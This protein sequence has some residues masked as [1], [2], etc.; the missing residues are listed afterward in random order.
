MSRVTEPVEALVAGSRTAALL[1]S[2]FCVGYGV[3]T[4][5]FGDSLWGSRAYDTAQMTPVAPQSWGVA[6]LA[7]G[8][9]GV[10]GVARRQGGLI[11]WGCG[12]AGIWCY[13]FS[14]LFLADALKRHE[15]FGATGWWVY[16]ILGTLM[17]NRAIQARRV[18]A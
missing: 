8:I 5:V 2:A 3:L 6:L 17:I 4:L 18:G 10:V 14:I 15:A 13:V 1:Y 12:L 11:V 9:M 16:L 7:F